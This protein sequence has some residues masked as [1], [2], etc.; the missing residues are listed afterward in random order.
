MAG[1]S[2]ACL[3]HVMVTVL[4]NPNSLPRSRSESTPDQA[5][6][7]LLEASTRTPLV[8]DPARFMS[9]WHAQ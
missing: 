9:C 7:P 6:L 5:S 3:Q 2:D 8:S 4:M 1:C